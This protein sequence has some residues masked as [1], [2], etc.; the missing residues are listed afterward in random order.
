MSDLR[1]KLQSWRGYSAYE[2]AVNNGYAGTEQQWLQSLRGA[3]GRTTCVNGRQADENGRITLS[4]ED[5]AVSTAPGAQSLAQLG[6]Q[7]DDLRSR[8]TLGDGVIDVGGCYIDNA[9]FR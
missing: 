4:G 5:I 1:L 7:M 3:D 8:I 9:L 2:V 6:A